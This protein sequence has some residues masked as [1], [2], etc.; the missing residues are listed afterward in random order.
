MSTVLQV[1]NRK[2]L[3]LDRNEKV[4]PDHIS[5][6]HAAM[7]VEQS[8]NFFQLQNSPI[9]SVLYDFETDKLDEYI[10]GKFGKVEYEPKH[11]HLLVNRIKEFKIPADT[12]KWVMKYFQMI[13]D[14][15]GVEAAVYLMLNTTT[16]DWFVLCVPQLD[17]SGASVSYLLPKAPDTNITGSDARLYEACFKD[18][19]AA[20]LMATALKQ[21]EDALHD[22]Y[23]IAGTIHS[24]CNFG[25]FH[26]GVDDRDE[27]GFDGLHITIGN[28]R[29]GFSFSCRYM[30]KGAEFNC[31]LTDVIDVENVEALHD[32]EKIEVSQYAM[33][34]MMPKLGS[35]HTSSVS[36]WTS[37]KT[38]SSS[39]KNVS[40]FG[41]GG[42]NVNSYDLNNDREH[43]DNILYMNQLQILY[44]IENDAIMFVRYNYYLS[45]KNRFPASEF[46]PM[47]DVE[48]SKKMLKRHYEYKKKQK[49]AQK[50]H[51]G[52][53][54]IND[55]RLNKLYPSGKKLEF[56][57]KV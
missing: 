11:V 41:H 55:A 43:D 39:D 20:A 28:V 8:G 17:C 54:L 56:V 30:I 6:T 22:G 26:S 53:F 10:D 19:N 50:N 2:L 5:N 23:Q 35:R 25:A 14:E 18:K 34:L 44:D 49:I 38:D 33:D 32:I 16:K 1:K 45:N 42:S 36:V 21:Y 3:Q 9:Y 4:P 27:L 12:I 29:S 52:I 46:I 47:A 13:Y 51:H 31:E 24:H 48:P 7:L 40:F 37:K 57:K 15:H